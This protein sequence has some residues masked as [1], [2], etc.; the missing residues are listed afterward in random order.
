MTK[1]PEQLLSM[2]DIAAE[3]GLEYGT[4]RKYRSEGRLPEPD[5]FPTE[6]RPRWR[7]ETILRWQA[8]RPGSGHRL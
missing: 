2:R 8:A 5:E 3:L 1:D 4:I 7:R 6:D